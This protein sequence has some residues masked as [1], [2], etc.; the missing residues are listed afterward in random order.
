MPGQSTIEAG[1]TTF[2]CSSAVEVR[3]LN[4]EPAGNRPA[5]PISNGT[6]ALSATARTAPV[7][8]RTATRAAG[9]DTVATALSAAV[10]TARSSVVRT[11]LPA[12]PGCSASTPVEVEIR[13]P[14]LPASR[15]LSARCRPER[16]SWSV[17][18]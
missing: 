12:W 18:S 10:C 1:C 14:G 3:I 11:A 2:A 16:P 6:C 5:S 17:P 8:G 9:F 15:S 7:D 13:S 4:V